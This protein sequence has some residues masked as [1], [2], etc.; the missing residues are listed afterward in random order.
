MALQNQTRLTHV[1]LEQARMIPLDDVKYD[2]HVSADDRT[3]IPR[4]DQLVFHDGLPLRSRRAALY[5]T[6]HLFVVG[7]RRR[8][9]RTYVS[10]CPP[11][12]EDSVQDR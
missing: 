1:S 4:D 7:E 9:C 10:P 3:V 2:I 5:V 12:C 6:P 8:S 11:S